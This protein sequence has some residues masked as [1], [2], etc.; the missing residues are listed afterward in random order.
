MALQTPNGVRI[1]DDVAEAGHGVSFGNGK[2]RAAIQPGSRGS[3]G[4]GRV[5]LLELEDHHCRAVMC[6][7]DYTQPRYCG[8][9][10][11]YKSWCEQHATRFFEKRGRP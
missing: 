3:E 8:K 1:G 6:G 7:G 9:P 2:T 10:A 5:S 11:T 4:V